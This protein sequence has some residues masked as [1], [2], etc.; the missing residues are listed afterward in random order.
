VSS[1][2]KEEFLELLEKDREFRYAVAGYLSLSEILKR[3]EEHDKKFNEILSRLEE[4]DKKFLK[5]FKKLEEHDRKF[6]EIV[7]H[8]RRLE[9]EFVMLSKRVEVT[10]GSMG[11]RWGRD[12]EMMVYEIFKEVL[13]K[14]GIPL[15]KVKKFTYVDHDGS[16]TGLRGRKIEVDLLIR[17]HDVVVIEVKSY[18]DEEDMDFLRD[19]TMYVERILNKRVI[20]AYMITVNVTR[21]AIERA[22]QLGIEVV[23]GNIID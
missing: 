2:L 15:E 13:E 14:K 6:N 23:Y 4:H 20:K 5:I 11:R 3:L 18:A 7:E 22:K 17:D 21:D 9:R 1:S 16:V 8:I 12:L 10:I 19:K